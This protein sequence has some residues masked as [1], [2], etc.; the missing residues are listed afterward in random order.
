VNWTKPTEPASER[1]TPTIRRRFSTCATL[2]PLATID[3][4]GKLA[5]ARRI[6]AAAM[7]RYTSMPVRI[8]AR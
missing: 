5:K 8:V 3:A 7:A 4:T 2:A 6:S 1:T